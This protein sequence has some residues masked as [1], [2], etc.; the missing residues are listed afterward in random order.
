MPAKFMVD[1]VTIENYVKFFTDP[2]YTAVLI[3]TIRVA[4]ITHRDLPACWAFRWPI[5]GAHAIALQE[6]ADH[7]W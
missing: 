4:L 1:A 2:F 3:R 6:P 7:G 5:A